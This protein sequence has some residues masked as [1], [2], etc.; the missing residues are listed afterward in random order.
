MGDGPEFDSET[1]ERNRGGE[2][3]HSFL[4]LDKGQYTQAR[5]VRTSN[6][7]AIVS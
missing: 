4:A 6:L 5:M 1:R 3:C 2:L 7:Y